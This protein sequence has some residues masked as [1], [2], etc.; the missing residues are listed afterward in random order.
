MSYPGGPPVG[1]PGP[2]QNQPG[3][4]FP[5]PPGYPQQPGY[6]QGQPGY[7]QGQPGYPTAQPGYPTPQPPGYPAPGGYPGA[8]TPPPPKKSKTG[9]IIG[10]VVGAIVLCIGGVVGIGALVYNMRDTTETPSGPTQAAQPSPSTQAPAETTFTDP[11]T[12]GPLKKNS[13]Q[14]AAEES[15]RALT[16]SGIEKP[17][18]VSYQD[19]ANESRTV[20]VWGGT[21]KIFG[22]GGRQVQLDAFFTSAESQFP[23]ATPTGRSTVSSGSAGGQAECEKLGGLGV[24]VTLCAWAGDDALLGMLFA[25]YEPAEAGP[26]VEEILA[27]VVQ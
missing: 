12:I 17:F 22:A 26:L 1:D 6:P 9:L 13:D 10:I 8:P 18:A 15:R 14:S 20:L 2:Q 24:A 23:G 5:P 21:G 3:Q 4:G 27:G 19:S 11:D 7:P 25:G 16:G